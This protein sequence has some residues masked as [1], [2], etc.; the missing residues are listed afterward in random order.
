[1]IVKS[2]K[3]LANNKYKV[4]IDNEEYKFNENIIV[5]YRLVKGKEVTRDILNLA[6]KENDY[7]SLYLK[8]EK[9]VIT[10]NKSEREIIRYLKNKNA[11]PD[12]IN[13]IIL[14]LK[15]NK[16]IDDSN[17]INDLINSLIKKFNGIKMI[18]AKLHQKGFDDDL[19]KSS[20]S[21]IDYDYYCNILE[22]L[23]NKIRN[24]YDK[25]DNYTRINKIKSYL[26]QRGYTYSDIQTLKIK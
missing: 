9:Y 20:L 13:K 4:L 3:R 25:Y 2:L 19:I 26:L 7:D 1:M 21:V 5:N 12:T 15:K 17:L 11:T 18:E 24:K 10:Y 16:L 6:I 14:K 23:Y 8:T 22:I